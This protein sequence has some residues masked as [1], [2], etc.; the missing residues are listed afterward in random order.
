MIIED[1]L[2]IIITGTSR[3]IGK[4]LALHLLEKNFIVIGISRTIPRIEHENYH[5]IKADLTND[6]DFAE[7]EL[8]LLT[9]KNIYALINNAGTANLNHFLFT[10]S[11]KTDQVLRLNFVAVLKMCQ[12]VVK[13]MMPLK[14]GRII[15]FT[16]VAVPLG[17]EGEAIYAA[18]KSAI[19][20][21]SEVISKE[22]SSYGITSNCIGPN[23]IQTALIKNVPNKKI[24]ELLGKQAIK[25]LGSFEDVFNL[26]DFYL[27]KESSFVTGQKIY[28]GGI[29]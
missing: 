9:F 5:H 20:T 8:N 28:L 11:K 21:F 3:G 7:V 29:H 2:E 23:P 1:K 22:I 18:S 26:V 14:R 25:K 16:S 4:S 24:N 17:L 15:N 10:T 12:I 6:E 27:K 13:K 19:E